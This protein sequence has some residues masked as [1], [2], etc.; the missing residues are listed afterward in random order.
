MNFEKEELQKLMDRYPAIKFIITNLYKGEA[1]IWL[2]ISPAW[3]HRG[4][5][6]YFVINLTFGIAFLL[7]RAIDSYIYKNELDLRRAVADEWDEYRKR[8]ELEIKACTFSAVI[9]FMAAGICFGEL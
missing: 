7:Q 2:L 3:F 6:I 8:L 1:F 5:K 9:A 4:E